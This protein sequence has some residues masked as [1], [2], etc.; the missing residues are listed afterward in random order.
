[1]LALT[2]EL[3]RAAGEDGVKHKRDLRFAGAQVAAMRAKKMNW[4]EIAA[5]LN[6]SQATARNWLRVHGE[7]ESGSE[8]Y[9][10][11]PRVRAAITLLESLGYQVTPPAK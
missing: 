11:P 6:I 5:A 1:V 10:T 2:E 9:D 7:V 4:A 8:K 3:G